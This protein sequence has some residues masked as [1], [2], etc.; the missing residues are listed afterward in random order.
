MKS[1]LVMGFRIIKT[2]QGNIYILKRNGAYCLAKF[3][4]LASLDDMLFVNNQ[5]WFSS[6]KE[7]ELI[8]DKE[9]NITS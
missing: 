5:C 9:Y 1:K 6:I 2:N 3:Q 7:I 4:S 8:F